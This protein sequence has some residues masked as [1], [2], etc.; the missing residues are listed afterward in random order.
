MKTWI[1]FGVVIPKSASVHCAVNKTDVV[2]VGKQRIVDGVESIITE[3]KYSCFVAT[4]M[5][6]IESKSARQHHIE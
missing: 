2:I 3:G 4:K 5:D 6:C 1:I